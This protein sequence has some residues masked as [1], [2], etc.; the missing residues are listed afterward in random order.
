MLQLID[1]YEPKAFIMS[2]EPKMFRG[3]YLTAMMNRRL[4]RKPSKWEQSDQETKSVIEK[5]VAEIRN[6]TET[7]KHDWFEE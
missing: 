7:L 4:K 5:T 3:G 1:Q 2:F 6:E